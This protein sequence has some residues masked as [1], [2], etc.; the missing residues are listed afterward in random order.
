MKYD[1]ETIVNRSELY[2]RKWER[3]NK[4]EHV[5]DLPPFSVADLDFNYPPQVIA[6]FKEYASE[7]IFGYSRPNAAYYQSFIDWCERRLDYRVERDWI[8][9]GNGVVPAIYTAILAYSEEDDGVMIMTPVYPPFAQM[10]NDTKRKLIA[11]PL[12]NNDY[13]YEIDLEQLEAQAK[14]ADTKLLV[15]CS[16]HNPVGR[17]WT[18]AELLEVDRICAENNVIVISD[19]IHMDL[20]LEGHKHHVFSTISDRAQNNSL[21][22]TSASKT[23]NIA[24]A[25]TSMTIIA[26]EDLRNKFQAV[27]DRTAFFGINAFGFKLAELSYNLAEDWLDELLELI[28]S[29]HKYLYNYINEQIEGLRA[30]PLEGTYLQWIDFSGLNMADDELFDF[31]FEKTGLFLTPGLGY[32]EGGSQFL[33]WNI[34]TPRKVMEKGLEQL[35]LAV[36]EF[37][38]SN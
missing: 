25:Q 16:P 3:M 8:L 34:A 4:S 10:V 14:K 31:V 32:G 24:G 12:I 22:L 9:D 19:E 33:R 18:K 6:G 2:S 13:H 27:L 21:I 7:M 15:F 11:M 17:V 35:K 37:M 5:R 28:S 36:D 26:S 38:S 29:N 30:I 23:F 1:F 20:I